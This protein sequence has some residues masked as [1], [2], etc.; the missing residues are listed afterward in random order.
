MVRIV[1]ARRADEARLAD[2][3]Q[4]Y[5][6][7]LKAYY[8]TVSAQ[9]ELARYFTEPGRLPCLLYDDCAWIGF[10]LVND[11]SRPGMPDHTV[12]EFTVFP[13]FRGAERG[14]S[15]ARALFALYPGRWRVKFIEKNIPASHFWERVT[16]AYPRTVRTL[17]GGE[18]RI[19][20][21]T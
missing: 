11:H 5:L 2:A 4:D 9:P 13:A 3:L 6:R 15:A 21:Q 18:H 20:L 17:P 14:M 16:A 12:A 1:P 10:A 19:S 8:A 7:E